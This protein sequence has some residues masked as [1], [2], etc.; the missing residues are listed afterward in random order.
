MQRDI[1][2]GAATGAVDEDGRADDLRAR[3]AYRVE[4]VL[5]GSA[6]RHDVVDDQHSLPRA[7]LEPATEL[8][9]PT[10]LR[11]LGI[12]RPQLHLTRDLMREDDAAGRRSRDGPRR[13]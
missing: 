13:D 12:D 7:E 10:A 2:A 5:D 1:E 8:P 11:P 3:A 4:R 9:A 6:G